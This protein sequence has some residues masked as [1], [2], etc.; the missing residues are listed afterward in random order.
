MNQSGHEANIMQQVASVRK[1]GNE[2]EVTRM[3]A[4]LKS[5][6]LYFNIITLPVSTKLQ[7]E[8]KNNQT[9]KQKILIIKTSGPFS[10]PIICTWVS[11][12][13]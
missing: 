1:R 11:E 12:D 13:N 2:S 8:N 5:R 9:Y 4:A 3:T 7:E 10:S 6:H